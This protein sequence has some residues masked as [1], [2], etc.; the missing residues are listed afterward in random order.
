MKDY[1]VE[2]EITTAVGECSPSKKFFNVLIMFLLP[3]KVNGHGISIP[4]FSVQC[5][6]GPVTSPLIFP[7]LMVK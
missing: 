5:W 2:L 3:E 4:P 7:S 6:R 1:D